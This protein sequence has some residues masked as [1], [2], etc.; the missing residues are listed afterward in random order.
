MVSDEE[1]VGRLE[2]LLRHVDFSTITTADSIRQKLEGEFGVKLGDKEAFISHHINLYI[3]CHRPLVS[4][5]VHNEHRYHPQLEA[6][7]EEAGRNEENAH[8]EVKEQ[9]IEE[10]IKESTLLEGRKRGRPGG[11][12]KICGV[13][14]ELQAIVGE[15]AL[16]RTQIVKQLWTYIRANNLQ[17]P[18][19]KRNIICNDALRMVF[20][21]DST[22]MFQM[23]KLLAKHIWALDSRD[24]GSEPNAKRTANRNTS[25]PASPVP[26]SDSLA[27]FLGTDK[28]ETS[29]EEVVKRLSDYIKENELQ[30]PLDKGKIICDAKLQKLFSCENFVD[31]EMTKL[32][33]PHFLKG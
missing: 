24:D 16:P 14:P 6:K 23:N 10:P 11:L 26:I 21:T 17:D 31:F 30:D 27:L 20:D 33:A 12:N 22:D 9:N 28:I 25:G 1:L 2:T 29:H 4:A 3:Q 32:L 18:S 13:S 5:W 7:V 19:N 15:P 8:M